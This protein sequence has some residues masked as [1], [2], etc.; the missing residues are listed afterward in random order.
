MPV[1]SDPSL[2]RIYRR[3]NSKYFDGT[4]PDDTAVYYAPRQKRL[5]AAFYVNGQWHIEIDPVN[6]IASR[7]THIILL[8]E[9]SHIPLHPYAGHDKR[10]KK[11]IRR[12][13]S[14]GAYDQWL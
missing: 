5:G 7:F 10:F 13:M 8:H 14:L 3:Y 1:S 12:L 4:L 9:M 2:K 11:Q 6:T